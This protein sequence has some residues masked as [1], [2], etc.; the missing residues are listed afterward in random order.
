MRSGGHFIDDLLRPSVVIFIVWMIA[1]TVVLHIVAGDSA[2]KDIDFGAAVVSGA[3]I[4]YSVLLTVQSKRASS[5]ARF[6]ERWN[7]A[8]FTERRRTVSAI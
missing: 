2:K 7:D 6:A 8:A 1:G 5:A 3:G 4:V